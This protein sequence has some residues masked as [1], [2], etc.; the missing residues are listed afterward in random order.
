MRNIW[1]KELTFPE[2]AY[3]SPEL[4][5]ARDLGENKVRIGI[6]DLGV[7]SVKKL[8]H[9]RIA[10]SIDTEIKKGDTLGFVETSKMIW[11]IVTPLSGK[12]ITK[13]KA[14]NDG[15]PTILVKDPYGEGW[16]VEIEKTSNT[17]DELKRLYKGN[18]A[19]T[20]VWILEQAQAIVPL[21]E[22]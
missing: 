18:D 8:I 4:L 1:Q 13:N 12:L 22:E 19:A 2:D 17:E 9:I 16:L 6:S 11:E 20:K 14:L 3:Y 15:N 10:T 5:W 7:K 21:E